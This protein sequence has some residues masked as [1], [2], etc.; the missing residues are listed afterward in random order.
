M[1]EPLIP[2]F[3][4]W[5][6]NEIEDSSTCSCNL[7]QTFK[8]QFWLEDWK[9]FSRVI[10]FIIERKNWLYHG[11][12]Y[13]IVELQIILCSIVANS[14]NDTVVSTSQQPVSSEYMERKSKAEKITKNK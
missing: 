6:W 2:R 9:I 5:N 8:K 1:N 14:Q 10:V 3:P 7:L 12:N 13:Y 4:H 11:I